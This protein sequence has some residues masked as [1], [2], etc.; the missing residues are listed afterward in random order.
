MHFSYEFKKTTASVLNVGLVESK[1]LASKA[2]GK[3]TDV[4]IVAIVFNT[5]SGGRF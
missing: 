1:K 4:H 5:K 3:D 2:V